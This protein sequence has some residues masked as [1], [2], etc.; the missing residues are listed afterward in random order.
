MLRAFAIALVAFL[1]PSLA[2]VAGAATIHK[3]S[4]FRPTGRSTP[5]NRASLSA[6][7]S[8]V[9][10]SA[11]YG[12]PFRWTH[13]EGLSYLDDLRDE[14]T[15]E[16]IVDVSADGRTVLGA[17]SQEF[18]ATV[19]NH[20]VLWDNAGNVTELPNIGFTPSAVSG[21]ATTAVGHEGAPGQTPR[22]AVQWGSDLQPA[23]LDNDLLSV[24]AATDV[25]GDG[26][27]IVGWVG[28]NMDLR[29]AFRWEQGDDELVPLPPLPTGETISYLNAVSHNG[30]HALGAVLVDHRPRA[31]ILREHGPPLQLNTSDFEILATAISDDGNTVV[32]VM[33][34]GVGDRAFIWNPTHGV[35]DLR[36]VLANDYGLADELGDWRLTDIR[37]LSADGRTILGTAWEPTGPNQFTERLYIVNVPE[38]ST[39]ALATIG[40]LAMAGVIRQRKRR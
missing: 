14:A 24:S 7:G 38:P 2:D 4:G 28:T 30:K 18:G 20:W 16:Y 12:S 19:R 22:R 1:F 32:G 29:K 11:A 6:D 23:L 40:V 5:F 8:T 25:S 39:Y 36:D 31:V 13:D 34:G 33:G 27:V 15:L 35:R 9:V 37:G 3:F 17:T 21:D 26:N 10:G